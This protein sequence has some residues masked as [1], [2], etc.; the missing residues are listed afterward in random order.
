MVDRESFPMPVFIMLTAC[1]FLY[2]LPKKTVVPERSQLQTISG[3]EEK[4]IK[5]D[6]STKDI[7]VFPPCPE[8]VNDSADQYHY[9]FHTVDVLQIM[10]FIKSQ[11]F[12]SVESV[13]TA[14][15][16]AVQKDFRNENLVQD[17]YQIFTPY[18]PNISDFLQT[19]RERFPNSA[20]PL[21]AIAALSYKTGFEISGGSWL[22]NTPPE[23]FNDMRTMFRVSLAYID[24]ALQINPG[25]FYCFNLR[26]EIYA[27][28]GSFNEGIASF[29]DAIKVY[30]FS[31][32]N[33][34]SLLSYAG[35]RRGGSFDLMQQVVDWSVPFIAC[36]QRLAILQGIVYMERGDVSRVYAEAA[37]FYADALSIG[38]LGHFYFKRA[39]LHQEYDHWEDARLDIDSA[40][41]LR[42]QWYEYR[43]QRGDIYHHLAYDGQSMAKKVEYFNKYCDDI[44][45]VSAIIP[46]K[47][48]LKEGRAK[49]DTLLN[50]CKKKN[51]MELCVL[52]DWY[53]WKE[54]NAPGATPRFFTLKDQKQT[55]AIRYKEC[56]DYFTQN[57]Q[58]VYINVKYKWKNG[59][60][61]TFNESTGRYDYR[62]KVKMIDTLLYMAEV[63]G[64]GNNITQ[65][66]YKPYPQDTPTPW[67]R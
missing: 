67:E 13:F 60:Y 2:C 47:P 49:F 9:P 61:V 29:Q 18:W 19:W 45:F 14:V 44:L 50:L 31:F 3:H 59:Y 33:W 58:R 53:L 46:E 56:W 22:S 64:N 65:D 12:A 40:V 8:P 54:I 23:V 1:L 42:D 27:Y 4:K 37:Q 24:S 26:T 17:A 52:G 7:S 21:T 30:P 34:S 25:Q 16:V 15:E 55:R 32:S 10:E 43:L 57:G 66:W 28:T 41:A 35:P 36:N 11:D 38:Q 5:A 51:P 63:D 20:N 6:N 62:Y 39:I 48:S